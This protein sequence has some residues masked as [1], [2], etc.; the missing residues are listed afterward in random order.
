VSIYTGDGNKLSLTAL[1]KYDGEVEIVLYV[2]GQMMPKIKKMDV[3][4]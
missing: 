2:G 4:R 1:D 3:L